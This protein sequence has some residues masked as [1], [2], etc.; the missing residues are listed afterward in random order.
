MKTLSIA[1]IFLRMAKR[2]FLDGAV[3]LVLFFLPMELLFRLSSWT[4]TM[5]AWDIV[6]QICTII[7][8]L[9]L[10]SIGMA[11]LVSGV[12]C[13]LIGLSIGKATEK[14]EETV[15]AVVAIGSLAMIVLVLL[16]TLKVWLELVTGSIFIVG[17]AKYLL[18]LLVVGIFVPWVWKCGLLVTGNTISSNLAK[19]GKLVLTLSVLAGLV[20]GPKGIAVHDYHEIKENP[21]APPRLGIA[22]VILLSIDTLAAE[23]MSIYGYHLPTTPRL[24]AFARESYVFDNVFSS[25]N[26]TTPSVAS[27]LSGLYPITSGVHHQNSYFLERDQKKNLGQVLVD[28]GY[29]SVAIVANSNA[30]PLTLRITDSLS[31]TTEQPVR[32]VFVTDPI[33]EQLFRLKDRQT[34]VV[35]DTLL[36]PVLHFMPFDRADETSFWPPKMV[37]DRALPFIVNPRKPSFVWAHIAPPHSPYLPAAPFKYK[38]GN[39]KAFS[40]FGDFEGQL[41]NYLPKRQVEVDQQRLRYDEFILD[42]DAAVGD[43]LDNLKAMGRFDD[44]IIIITSDHGESFSKNYLTHGGP[45]LHQPLIHIPLLVHLPAQTEGK[46]IPFYAGQVDLLPTVMDLLDLAIPKWVEGESLKA[47]MLEGKPT[48]Q[49]KFSMNLDRDSRFVPPSNGTIAVMQ[50]GWKLVRYLATGK[51]ELYHLTSD[52]GEAADLASSN[53]EQAKEMRDLIYARF[54]LA[55]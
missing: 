32:K 18:L 21:I 12:G 41:G 10:I 20:I 46:R 40:T 7:L 1:A 50:N 43:F 34:Y 48:F 22:N 37:F 26:W 24:E 47:V 35:L 5:P 45:L 27:L 19:G 36:T 54:N 15:C 55:R 39:F 42:T 23:D 38:F 9:A 31:G 2:I 14:I 52:P 17:A 3:A 51:Q 16:R 49:P 13:V 30:H 8:L 4:L 11:L 28:N 33:F 25:S 53:P 44:S 6:N 29:Q